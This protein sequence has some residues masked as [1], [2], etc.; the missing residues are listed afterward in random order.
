MFLEISDCSAQLQNGVWII[1]YQDEDVDGGLD[2]T[3]GIVDTFSLDHHLNIY[4]T[5]ASICKK[6][7][8]LLF[9]TNGVY[10]ANANH[11][12]LLNSKDFNPGYGT[13]YWGNQDGGLDYPQMV[14]ILPIEEDSNLFDIF[15]LSYEKLPTPFGVDDAPLS[16]R[17]SRVDM[18]LDSGKGGVIEKAQI[19]VEDTLS[20]GRLTACRHANGRDWWVVCHKHWSTRYYI[21]LA[22]K[23]SVYAPKIQSIGDSLVYDA[24]GQNCF[25]LDGS[26]FVN[27]DPKYQDSTFD[28]MEFDRCEGLFFN[29]QN[30]H[31]PSCIPQSVAFSPSGRYLYVPCTAH[32][33]QY[34]TWA[35]DIQSTMTLV[36]VLNNQNNF[37]LLSSQML[38]PD[39][40]I[41]ISGWSG[42]E[43]FHVIE[44]PDAPG[45]S[46]NFVQDGLKLPTYNGDNS[47]P[48][49]VNYEL[50][51]I[52]GS[53]CDTLG[54]AT[55]N[56]SALNFEIYPNPA[57]SFTTLNYQS[58]QPIEIVISDLY[59]RQIE[60]M[61]LFPGAQKQ[62][63]DIRRLP[64]GIYLLSLKNTKGYFLSKKLVV[65]K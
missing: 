55:Q 47:V 27:V 19:V 10:I 30:L 64:N 17:F 54:L 7:G 22:T 58:N 26:K 4:S 20:T 39:N 38:G 50:G 43:Y 12:T 44:N 14:L 52:S 63:I 15:S 65:Q 45:M 61:F 56:V 3:S 25:S 21:I 2:F 29:H 46:C 18:S 49:G 31:T 53:T 34:D 42:Y 9:Y 28:Y 37:N 8:T 32:L 13:D 6:N 62:Y 40:K 59:G 5:S 1:G 23:D 11:D 41:Y 35:S 57:S 48:N 24:W 36:G 51:A 33:Y 60:E 16:L